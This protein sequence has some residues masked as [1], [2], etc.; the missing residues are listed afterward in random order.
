MP[1][2]VSSSGTGVSDSMAADGSGVTAGS[3]M[4]LTPDQTKHQ[5]NPSAAIIYCSSMH[6][7]RLDDRGV[8]KN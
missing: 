7:L 3:P 4:T 1:A 6:G 2:S 5:L 8:K